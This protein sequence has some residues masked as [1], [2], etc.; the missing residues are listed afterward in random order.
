[1]AGKTEITLKVMK[2][3]CFVHTVVIR[4]KLTQRHRT[5]AERGGAQPQKLAQHTDVLCDSA[6]HKVWHSSSFVRTEGSSVWAT[7]KM[8]TLGLVFSRNR[9][10]TF[11]PKQR[12]GAG[13]NYCTTFLLRA[14]FH[15][16]GWLFNI[17]NKQI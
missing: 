3:L 10:L 5:R 16:N 2:M 6:Q 17:P 7:V 4:R 14:S 13:F 1:M 9:S 12:S 11:H 8:L 15:G